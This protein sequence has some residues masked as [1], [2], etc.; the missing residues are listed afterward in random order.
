MNPCPCGYLAHPSGRCRCTPDQVQR[1]RGRLSGPLIDRIDLAID[2]PVPAPEAL[3]LAAAAAAPPETP[4]VRADVAA[5]RER[6][7]RR[8]GTTNARLSPAMVAR[9]CALTAHAERL[10]AQAVAKRSLSAR[11]CHRIAKVARTIA[12]LAGA[13]DVERE[14]VAEALAMRRFDSAPS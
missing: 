7:Q 10:L 3:S 14:H 12:D 8:Q 13:G 6:Q 1:Y 2:V 4:G 5:A 9:H 11:A